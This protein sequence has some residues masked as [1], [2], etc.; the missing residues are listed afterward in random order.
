ML[1]DPEDRE[2]IFHKDEVLCSTEAEDRIVLRDICNLSCMAIDEDA[3]DDDPELENEQNFNELL[4]YAGNSTLPSMDEFITEQWRHPVIQKLLKDGG[5]YLVRDELA[6][7]VHGTKNN[8]RF[9]VIVPQTLRERVLYHHHGTSITGHLGRDRVIEMMRTAYWWKG[10]NDS[11]EKWVRSC[12]LCARRKNVRRVNR[13]ELAHLVKTNPLDMV[14]IDLVGPL[15]ESDRGAKYILTM[16]DSF[17][18]FP[19][20]VAIPNKEAVSVAT[21]FFDNFVCTYG[22]PKALFS[23]RGTEF[24]AAMA[25]VCKRLSITKRPRVINRRPTGRSSG[26][27]GG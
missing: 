6:V 19:V 15:P 9:P 27:I 16:I 5:R 8:H 4:Q 25:E 23:D 17:T 2:N 10:M 21:A 20:A 18:R 1:S 14:Y 24:K 7:V 22:V 12:T 13:G 26:Y 11:V 3:E